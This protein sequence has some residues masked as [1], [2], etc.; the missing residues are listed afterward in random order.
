MA[1]K[2][3]DGLIPEKTECPFAKNCDFKKA[4]SCHHLGMEHATKF[5]CA[6]ARAFD[7]RKIKLI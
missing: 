6:A 1:N 2:L 3:I 4:G 7:M 5:S